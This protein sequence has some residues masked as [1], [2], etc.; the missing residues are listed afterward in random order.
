MSPRARARFRQWACAR[1]GLLRSEGWGSPSVSSGTASPARLR[2]GAKRL[3]P[4]GGR[5]HRGARGQGASR[6]RRPLPRRAARRFLQDGPH[7]ACSPVARARLRTRLRGP[8]TAAP[9]PFQP[10]GV[11]QRLRLRGQPHRGPPPPREGHP[12]RH[13]QRGLAGLDRRRLPRDVGRDTMKALRHPALHLILRLLLGGLFVY[14]SL[15]KIATPPAF[16][17]IVYQ[18]QVLG[19]VPSNLVAVILP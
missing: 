18:W 4:E 2:P 19:P 9:T 12:R 1:G 5:G 17:R 7:P 6:P 3:R 10:S 11:L 13:P 16:A 8:G 15:D 14:A